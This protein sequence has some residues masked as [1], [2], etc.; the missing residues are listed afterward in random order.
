MIQIEIDKD[1]GFC[2]GVTTA[3]EKAEYELNRMSVL[4]NHNCTLY[5]L[6]D[7]VHNGMEV[8]RLHAQGLKTI[9]H[10]ELRKLHDVKVLLRAQRNG[11]VRSKSV[12]IL[13]FSVCPCPSNV[14]L[15]G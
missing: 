9:N 8:E 3:I 12:T 2:F 5:C 4:T 15:K 1:S 6:G 11:P 13:R 7:I 10:E 14:P